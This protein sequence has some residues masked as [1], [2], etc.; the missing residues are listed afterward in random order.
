M[1]TIVNYGLGNVNSVANILNYLGIGYQVTSDPNLL[2]NAEKLILPGVGAFDNGMKLLKEKNLISALN[3][4]VNIKKTPILG[5]CLGMQLMCKHSEEGTTTGL[6]W[7]DAVV[8]KIKIPDNSGLK[9]PHMGWSTLKIEKEN[10]LLNINDDEQ[11]FYFVHSYHVVCNNSSD[12]LATTH[13]GSKIIA[14]FSHDNIF[15]VQ[16]HPEK[17]HRFGF[18]LFKKFIKL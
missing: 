17:S 16:F 5:I 11:R 13:F 6:G 3:E 12:I 14:S 2:Y 18:S 15:G 8:Q 10:V 9:V 7:I 1:I 4:A